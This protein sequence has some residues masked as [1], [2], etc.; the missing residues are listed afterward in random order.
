MFTAYFDASGDD[1]S[2]LALAVCGFIAHAGAWIDWEQEWLE[3]L[4]RDGLDYFHRTEL[5]GWEPTKLSRLIEDLS[6]IIRD[7]VARKIGISILNEHLKEVMTNEERKEWRV[8]SY[9]VA[10]RTAAVEARLWASTDGLRIPELVFEKGD[11]GS[12]DLKHL[13]ESQ[14]YPSPVFKP[15]KKQI[16]RKSG[17]PMEPAIPLQAADLYAYEVFHRTRRFQETPEKSRLPE[18]LDKIPGDPG[19]IGVKNLTFL[20]ELFEQDGSLI[21][22]TAVKLKLD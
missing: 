12:G 16:N 13:L 14:G 6:Q 7:H 21:A 17:L 22:T 18:A 1:H 5:H 9:S 8:K 15:K 10:G 4:R 2:Q 3:R 19:R 11:V 20:R